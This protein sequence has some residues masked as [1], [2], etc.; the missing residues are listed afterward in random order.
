MALLL[1]APVVAVAEPPPPTPYVDAVQRALAILQGAAAPDTVPAIDALSVLVRGTGRSQPE[2]IADLRSR[3][4]EYDDARARLTA[5]LDALDEPPRTADP[6][7]AQRRLHEVLSMSRYDP[8]HRPPSLWDRFVRWVQD[9]IAALLRLLFGSG[10]GG[11]APVW[12]FYVVAIAIIAAV[13]FVLFRAA[14]GR[15]GQSLALSPE[16]PRP[17][18]DF[19]ADADRLA[20]AGDRVGAIRALCAAVAATLAGEHS[21]AGSALTVREIFRKSP[22]F[23]SLQPLLL[24]FEAAVYGGREVDEASYARA[25]AV[26][27]WFRAAATTTEAA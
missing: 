13:A 4:P 12:T 5:L 20:A 18:A 2:I 11:V 15:L 21:W 27:A 19:F 23:R 14:R 16:G 22:D 17:P 25:A 26:A 9:R 8:L 7:L 6:Q 3:P 24:P 1:L 10:S